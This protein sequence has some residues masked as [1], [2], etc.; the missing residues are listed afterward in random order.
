MFVMPLV[1]DMHTDIV[2]DCGVFQPFAFAI[3]HA[4]NAAGL[5]EQGDRQPRHLLRV[6]GPVIA[7][8]GKLE[9]AAA[10]DV[11]I[12]I[13]LGDL[14]AMPCDVVEYQPFTQ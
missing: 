5:I 11:G 4:V 6:F 13:R 7:A 10:A 12:A 14:L 9:H 2:K 8:F 3:G 1:T